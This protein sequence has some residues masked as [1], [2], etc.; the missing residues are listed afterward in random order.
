MP[1]SFLLGVGAVVSRS[2][3]GVISVFFLPLFCLVEFV[4]CGAFDSLGTPVPFGMSQGLMGPLS[5]S[6]LWVPFVWWSPVGLCVCFRYSSDSFTSKVPVATW[7]PFGM[8]L[9]SVGTLSRSGLWFLSSVVL[10]FCPHSH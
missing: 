4:S 9:S 5:R 3:A 2:S 10:P 8:S 7:S 1:V 6:G